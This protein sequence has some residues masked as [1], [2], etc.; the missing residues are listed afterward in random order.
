MFVPM[1]A[2]LRRAAEPDAEAIARLHIS[3]WQSAYRRQLPDSFLDGLT[4][5]LPS[6][7]DFWR[8]HCSIQSSAGQEIWIA[9]VDRALHAFT[10]LGPARRDDEAGLGEIYALY[11]DPLHWNQG[12]GRSLLTHASERLFRQYTS[13][14]LWV[15]ASNVRARHFYE[16]S[17]WA[18]DGAIKIENLPDGTELCEVRYRVFCTRLKE[19]S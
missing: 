7:T 2:L 18:P 8:M 5:E 16:R 9:E 15:L 17:G 13:A 4:E 3:S 12:I 11:V 1:T 10:A 19:E 14:V 6:R